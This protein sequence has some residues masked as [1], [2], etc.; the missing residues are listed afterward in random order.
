[1]HVILATVGTDGDSFPH[2]GLGVALRARGH[3]FTLAAPEPSRSRAHALGLEFRPL[4]TSAEL[5]RFLADPD[6]WHPLRSA[7]MSA[8]WGGPMISDQYEALAT[9][10]GEPGSV[11][12]AHPGIL[13][14]RLVQE[15]LGTPTASLLLQ[16]GLV[17]SIFE[18]PKL[19]V[20]IPIP[21][22]LPFPLRRIFRLGFDAF[23]YASIGPWLNRVRADL[24][25]SPVR[26]FFR[27]WLS[28]DL[29]IGLFPDWCAAPQPDWPPQLRLVGSAGSMA[30]KV[31]C[32]RNCA[33]S[34]K[35]NRRQ[36]PSLSAP[37]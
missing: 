27:W 29:V 6:L 37:K 28:P 23:G 31:R 24:G 3:R 26:R 14:A 19:P 12:V 30:S 13:A 21:A 11:L 34:V 9:L 8:R 18:P 32:P 36:S 20:G 16:P 33:R 1:M 35:K 4:V 15:K 2:V 7:I 5:E 17:P 22:W 10:A 25:L